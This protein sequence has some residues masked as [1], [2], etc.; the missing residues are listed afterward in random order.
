MTNKIRIYKLAQDLDRDYK[1]ILEE[2]KELGIKAKSHVSSVTEEEAGLIKESFKEQKQEP[3]PE[4]K[5]EVQ[6]EQIRRDIIPRSPVVTVMGHVDHGKTQ[7]LDTI[8]HTN[9]IARESGGITQH[10]GACKVDLEGKG[11]IVFIDTPG[12]EAFT[13]MRARGARITDIVVLVIAGDDGVMPQTIEAINHAKA[14][15]VPIIVAINKMDLPEFDAEKVRTQLSHHGILTENWGGDVIAIEISAKK[16]QHVDELL[17]MILLQAEMLELKAPIDGPV[18]G[19]VIET[20]LDKQTGPTGTIVVTEGTLKIGDSFVCGTVSGKVKAMTDEASLRLKTASP[21]TPVRIL[22]FEGLAMTGDILNVVEDKISA[23]E[24]VG[25]RKLKIQ[26]DEVSQSGQVTLEDLQKQLLG[27]ENKE[28]RIILKTDVTGSLEAIK[29]ALIKLQIE[30]VAL[31]IIHSGVGA[32]TRK[33]IMLAS[34]SNAIIISFNISTSGGIMKEAECEGVQI[35]NYR[36]IYE[37]IDDIKKSLE[38]MLEPEESEITLGQAEVKRIYIISGVGTIAGS[39]VINGQILRKA[40]VRVLRDSKIVY[41]GSLA[42]LKRFK[43]DV[44]EVNQGYE[45]GIN[46]DNF[47]DVKVSDIIESFQLEKRK[48][49]LEEAQ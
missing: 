16:N 33:D 27:E 5:E 43:N 49:T 9:V 30:E 14:A 21:S 41:V 25:K 7:L 45:C 11:S 47:N 18:K 3:K 24:I 1:I 48:R 20:E 31:N 10:I 44:A 38:G 46:I 36:V 8:R 28:L 6:V 22:G 2:A 42:A 13:A 29:D 39:N 35:R 12:H 23:R 15:D 17:E 4:I 34:A 26:K 32:V 40:Q 37:I 19:I